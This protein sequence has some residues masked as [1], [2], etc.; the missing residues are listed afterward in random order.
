MKPI[1]IWWTQRQR[2][3]ATVRISSLFPLR[4]CV[5]YDAFLG[6][7]TAVIAAE[8]TGRVCYGI[9]IDPAYVDLGVIR[10]QNLTGKQ[11]ILDGHGATLAHVAQGRR[12]AAE[13]A[14][15]EEVIS[16]RES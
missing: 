2:T 10:W 15:K 11:A 3:G 12:M 8:V 9:E 1:C 13:D 16:M 6:S 14:I 4:S 7:S 5:F